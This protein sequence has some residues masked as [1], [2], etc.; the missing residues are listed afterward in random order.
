D[1]DDTPD[2]ATDSV[3]MTSSHSGPHYSVP[4]SL[5]FGEGA[6]D[7]NGTVDLDQGPMQH[8]IAGCVACHMGEESNHTFGPETDY[9]V[10]C[11]GATSNFD[12]HGAPTKME[13]A[14]HAIEL[15]FVT[16]GALED[17]GE[18]GFDQTASG[19]SPTVLTGVQ[20]SAFWNYLVLHSDHGHLYHNPPYVK[21]MINNMEENLG[22]TQTTW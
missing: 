2:D 10:D 12:I 18:G 20:F 22:M 7:R 4:G 6:D 16:L 11:H 5:I 21:A 14:I 19:G 13:D 8:A 17:D 15:A 1:Y 3:S 9:C